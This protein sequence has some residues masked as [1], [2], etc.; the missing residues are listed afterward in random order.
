MAARS[1][2]SQTIDPKNWKRVALLADRLG[3]PKS[4]LL[5]EILSADNLE[6]VV[7]ALRKPALA[8]QRLDT[9]DTLKQGQEIGEA[10]V[11]YLETRD[12]LLTPGEQD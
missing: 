11:R 9:I 10:V 12:K 1:S 2:I 5:D 7:E 3:V 4:R 6:L 8:S